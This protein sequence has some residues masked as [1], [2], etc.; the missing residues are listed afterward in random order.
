MHG[1]AGAV[2]TEG[3]TLG[4]AAAQA[5][6]WLVVAVSNLAT[7]SLLP[8]PVH[9]PA[10]RFLHYWFDVSQMVALGLLAATVTW[11]WQR[12]LGE[13]RLLATLA[14]AGFALLLGLV[15]LEPDFK[16]WSERIDHPWLSFVG[17]ALASQSVPLAL[18]VGRKLAKPR[19]RALGLALGLSVL[20]LHH[21]L[22]PG[23]YPGIHVF[24]VF[25]AATL[26]GASAT[27]VPLPRFSRLALGRPR[28]KLLIAPLA[29]TGVASLVLW[30]PPAV[31]TEIFQVSG[32]VLFPYLAKAQTASRTATNFENDTTSHRFIAPEWLASR[33]R[34]PAIPASTPS[35]AP[36]RP[37]VILLTIDAL[38]FDVVE[39]LRKAGRF[40]NIER[41]AR[42]SV[43]FTNAR[44]PSSGTRHTMTSIFS[45]KYASALRSKRGKYRD[46]GPK[47][48]EFIRRAGFRTLYV[49]SYSEISARTGR[50]GRFD[51]EF[52]AKS[53]QKGQEHPLA[54]DVLPI[55]LRAL[56]RSRDRPTFLYMHWLDPH[57]PY[58]SQGTHGSRLE[59][60]A[61]EAEACDRKLGELFAHLEK[62]KAL[63]RVILVL[64]SDH[65]EAFGDHGVFAHG[66][67]LYEPLLRVP[68]FVRVPGVKPARIDVPVSGI[69]IGATLL[70][71]MGADTPGSFMGQSLVPYLRGERPELTRPI[72]GDTGWVQ[73]VV[74]GKYKVIDDARRNLVE[75]YDLSKDPGERDNLFGTLDGEDEL[76]LKALR[77]FF[78]TRQGPP[79]RRMTANLAKRR[80][81]VAD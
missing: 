17:A 34:L 40:P 78:S 5:L 41:L 69:D 77:H 45:S 79:S 35:L 39:Q 43:E 74:I 60:Q 55:A 48:P 67:A 27:G 16:N 38:R 71:L 21:V 24:W 25:A 8:F 31:A 33:E 59:R 30:P 44:S 11:G 12:L 13:R 70:D 29:A 63:D 65:G 46:K 57:H 76:M 37:I 50:L 81:S 19:W 42:E 61:R 62:R 10:T 66:M 9:H 7:I 18:L 2:E 28:L 20:S 72:V 6:A 22:L 73:S 23:D 68:F 54:V 32:S 51:R 80:S 4:P 26:M 14:L 58:D 15:A 36:E 64:T 3:P 53:T 75:V 52:E 49:S 56:D 1:G 47:L